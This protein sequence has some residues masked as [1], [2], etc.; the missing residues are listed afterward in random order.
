MIWLSRKEEKEGAERVVIYVKTVLNGK[1][2]GDV[3][4]GGKNIKRS[5]VQ[6]S[7]EFR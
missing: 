1:H 2:V 6:Q 5:V 7:F 4:G 3:R